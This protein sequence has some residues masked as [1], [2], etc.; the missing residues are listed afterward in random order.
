[1]RPAEP[2]G[3]TPI[4]AAYLRPNNSVSVAALPSMQ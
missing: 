2:M 1:M 3:A 4:G